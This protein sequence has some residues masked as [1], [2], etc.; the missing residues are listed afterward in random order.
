M[1]ESKNLPAPLRQVWKP[2]WL[3]SLGVHG[4]LLAIPL[5]TEQ[6]SKPV[7]EEKPEELV[8]L[9][10]I[11]TSPGPVTVAPEAEKERLAPRI[12]RRSPRKPPVASTQPTP[13]PAKPAA[14]KPTPA[15]VSP[16]QQPVAIA[17]FSP[18]SAIEIDPQK[19][20]LLP[21]PEEIADPTPS[22]DVAVSP[23]PN[24][25]PIAI[26]DIQGI[27]ID[28]TWQAV[29][30]PNQAIAA[31]EMFVQADGKPYPDIVGQIAQV[32]NKNPDVVFEEFFRL[33]LAS[34]NFQVEPFG[35]YAPGG[36]LYKLT[37]KGS[38][39]TP[40]YL[41]LAPDKQGTGTIVTIWK[42]YPSSEE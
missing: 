21:P 19:Q 42:K 15:V 26:A 22:L 11:E 1:I 20:E 25:K 37:P 18:P 29:E 6:K 30:Q 14:S 17:P 33:Q 7:V 13:L 38:N 10:Q 28:P 41:T 36:G 39:T 5:P 40:L 12:S 34:A 2:M 35:T 9:T 4:M 31:A 3:V 8:R 24:S 23:S 16:Q 32:P 27:P